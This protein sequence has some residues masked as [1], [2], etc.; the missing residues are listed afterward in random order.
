MELDIDRIARVVGKTSLEKVREAYD[1]VRNSRIS[2]FLVGPSGCGKSTIASY[3]AKKY[4]TRFKTKVHYVQVS[5]DQTKTSLILG[6]KLVNGSLVPSRGVIAQAMAEGS[7]VIVDEATHATAEILLMLNSVLD[8][9]AVTSI[10]D[11][12]VYAA[13][14]FRIIFCANTSSYAGNVR[15]P[16]SFAR[17][18]LA[19]PCDYPPREEEILIAS[20]IVKS[21]ASEK[22]AVEDCVLNYLVSLMR[23]VRT[24]A[25][26]VCVT[27]VAGALIRLG[28]Y[29]KNESNDHAILASITNR[30]SGESELRSI[31][32]RIYGQSGDT[33]SVRQIVEDTNVKGFFSFMSKV[34][35]ARFSAIIFSSFMGDLDI[36]GNNKA[37]SDAK[38]KLKGALP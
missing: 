11:D 17:R 6:L 13:D 21:I 10:G 22:T 14:T 15:L 28:V 36:Q 26:P 32:R 24:D 29:S 27:N 30:V 19:I 1:I 38:T 33:L 4:A 7:I 31:Y 18:V 34:G 2:P 25:F 20:S 3:V 9:I 8:R 12:I 37:I 35:K 23:D 5:P 16:Q